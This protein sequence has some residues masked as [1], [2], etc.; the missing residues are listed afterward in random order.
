[1]KPVCRSC[2]MTHSTEKN[3]YFG[4]GSYAKGVKQPD[5]SIKIVTGYIK[6]HKARY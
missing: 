3:P 5:G 1:M 2:G 4:A 6:P